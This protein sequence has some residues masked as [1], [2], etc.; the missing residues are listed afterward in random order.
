MLRQAKAQTLAPAELQFNIEAHQGKVSILQPLR[1]SS[2]FLTVS[3]FTLESMD[4]AEDHLILAAVTDSGELLDEETVRRLL[5]VPAQTGSAS[6]LP[7]PAQ[8]DEFAAKHQV[9]I[10]R[11]T[12]ER[13]A[14]FFEAEATKLDGWA[15]DLKVGLEREIKELDRLIKE[16]RRAATLALTLDE[17]LIAQKQIKSLE[18]QRSER[19][20]SLFDAQD[21][22][23]SQREALIAGIEAKLVQKQIHQQL[24]TSRWSL[25]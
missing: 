1:G 6:L 5:S 25:S 4:Q 2:G 10:Q 7:A 22:I 24:F 19:R 14:H 21:K 11:K 15:D 8:L 13:N 16:S 18:Q 9:E 12:S 17:K 3:Q 23:D 20:R